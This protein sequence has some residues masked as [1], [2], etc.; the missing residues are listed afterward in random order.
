MDEKNNNKPKKFILDFSEKKYSLDKLIAL[1]E[2]VNKNFDKK[3]SLIIKKHKLRKV[4]KVPK[5]KI[6]LWTYKG[7]KVTIPLN[8]RYLISMPFIYG[9]IIPAILF[10]ICIET[11]Q[12]VCF[13]LYGIPLVNKKGYFLYDRPLLNKLKFLEKINCYYC[14]YVNNLIRYSGEIGGRT[15]RY[16]CPIK[17][18]RR[19]NNAHSQYKN[20]LEDG[21]CEE[22]RDKWVGLRDFTD[23]EA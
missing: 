12:Q 16:W 20:F 1:K 4:I 6:K 8:W 22:M 23:L 5:I 7:K 17:Y 11:Y 2:E 19:I 13:R 21:T 15:E 18:E 9:M 10:H 14:S 3:I